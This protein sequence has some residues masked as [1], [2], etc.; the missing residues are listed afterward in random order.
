MLTTALFVFA[1]APTWTVDSV[2]TTL[3][4]TSRRGPAV[5]QAVTLS[6]GSE[7]MELTVKKFHMRFD[8]TEGL[9][10]GFKVTFLK[11]VKS[12]G[13]VTLSDLKIVR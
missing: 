6:N 7:T 4:H 5:T 13:S 2:H 8:G 10:K 3:V 1:A 9:Q 11:E 12:G